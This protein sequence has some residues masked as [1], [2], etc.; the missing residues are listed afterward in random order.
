MDGLVRISWRHW[1]KWFAGGGYHGN[2]LVA[3]SMAVREVV[4]S[5]A[6]A[7]ATAGGHR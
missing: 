2:V 6:V 1:A 3:A 5:T 4:D 7:V